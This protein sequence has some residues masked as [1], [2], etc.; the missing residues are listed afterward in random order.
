[1]ASRLSHKKVLSVREQWA[2]VRGLYPQFCCWVKD[3]VLL[4]EGDIQPTARGGV[5][6]VRIE[7]HA[8]DPPQVRVQS[9]ELRPREEGGRVPHV[10]SDNRL[11]L[12]VP[13]AG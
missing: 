3:G 2:R 12:Y 13:G 4:I 1:M 8:G 10:Y 11:C 6:R 7:Y 5:Y 9:P